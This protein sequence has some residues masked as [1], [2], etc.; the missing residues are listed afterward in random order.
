LSKN[1]SNFEEICPTE[2]SRI[3]QP[4]VPFNRRKVPNFTL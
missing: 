2:V 3:V 1:L 4:A